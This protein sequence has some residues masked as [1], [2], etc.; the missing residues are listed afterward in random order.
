[1][2]LAASANDDATDDDDEDEDEEEEA[3]VNGAQIEPTPSTNY[4]TD[5]TQHKTAHISTIHRQ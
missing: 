2:V 1:M 4:N 3:E 5:I